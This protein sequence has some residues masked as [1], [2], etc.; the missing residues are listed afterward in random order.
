M[1]ENMDWFAEFFTLKFLVGVLVVGV[2]VNIFSHY[3]IPP[4]DSLLG[5]VSFKWRTR[6]E[7][8]KKQYEQLLDRFE[9]DP[10]LVV[11]LVAERDES[12][13]MA[14][15]GGFLSTFI[16]LV[17]SSKVV[18][19]IS[20][21]VFPFIFTVSFMIFAVA[22]LLALNKVSLL[23]D[24]RKR[25]LAAARKMEGEL[26][27]P[28]LANLFDLPARS[29]PSADLTFPLAVLFKHSFLH[30]FIDPRRHAVDLPFEKS[31]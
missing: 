16:L 17:Q 27:Q 22:L 4:I 6:T 14:L 31:C 28:K 8:K 30:E 11:L 3:L 29:G 19:I 12:F 10:I 20:P 25:R 13:M 21:I 5:S 15:V 9:R 26:Q 23:V 18:F 24:I 1:G 2:A 7:R